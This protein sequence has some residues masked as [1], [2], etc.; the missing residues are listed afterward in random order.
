MSNCY[1]T[2]NLVIA[3]AYIVI[4]ILTSFI[5]MEYKKNWLVII[6]LSCFWLFYYLHM[7]TVALVLIFEIGIKVKQGRNY[8]KELKQLIGKTKDA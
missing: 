4:A 1:C 6:L 3:I 2:Y 5:L 7:L 8:Y